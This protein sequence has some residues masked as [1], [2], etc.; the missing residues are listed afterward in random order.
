MY[1]FQSIV[2]VLEILLQ[3][4]FA[5]AIVIFS[6][7]VVQGFKGSDVK[8]IIGKVLSIIIAIFMFIH[9][10]VPYLK[11]LPKLI[12]GKLIYS[13]EYVYD[14]SRPSKSSTEYIEVEGKTLEFFM[15]SGI[16]THQYY[17]IGYLPNTNRG[18]YLG[19]LGYDP[20][21]QETKV[22]F[23]AEGILIYVL[24]I[25]GVLLLMV[26][27]H[28]FRW[29]F[30]ILSCILSYPVN[31]YLLFDKGIKS[32]LWVTKYNDAFF[33]LVLQVLGLLLLFVFNFIE[34]RKDEEI[35]GTLFFAQVVAAGNMGSFIYNILR[36]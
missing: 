5:V 10:T 17:K 25:V 34:K 33:P 28:F 8:Y 7:A 27:A 30:L 36:W 19:Q 12:T 14:V 4:I 11:D 18:I 22:G 32:W 29:K 31:I 15:T 35:I 2:F 21:S 23:P 6:D 3:L 1:L 26:A 13:V 16:K 24:L 20:N 9:S